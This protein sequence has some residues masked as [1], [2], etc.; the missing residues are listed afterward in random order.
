MKLFSKKFANT[1]PYPAQ[2]T[3][4]VR[5]TLKARRIPCV[6]L[7]SHEVCRTTWNNSYGE[8]V[9]ETWKCED[10]AASGSNLYPI[11][12]LSYD[13]EKHAHNSIVLEGSKPAL[14]GYRSH[15]IELRKGYA[16]VT[17]A[18]CWVCT[19]CDSSSAVWPCLPLRHPM[20]AYQDAA[21]HAYN[22]LVAINPVTIDPTTGKPENDQE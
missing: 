17:S 5:P 16:G 4:P 13:A 22:N 15:N 1:I 8:P 7:R 14:G 11:D 19:D 2:N 21:E 9:R 3:E 18:W 10:C 12:E 20:A 6:I